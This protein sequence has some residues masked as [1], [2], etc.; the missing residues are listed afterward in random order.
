[1]VSP[2]CLAC[3]IGC[4][5]MV[6]AILDNLINIDIDMGVQYTGPVQEDSDTNTD[7]K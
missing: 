5:T 7:T 1:M 6:K 2:L 3:N 4:E